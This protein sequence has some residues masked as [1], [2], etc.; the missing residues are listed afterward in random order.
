MLKPFFAAMP[1]PLLFLLSGLSMVVASYWFRYH[2]A[3]GDHW[4]WITFPLVVYS[5]IAGGVLALWSR[6]KDMPRLSPLSL[7]LCL[8][9][10]VFIVFDSQTFLRPTFLTGT[11]LFTDS[12][13]MAA[14]LAFGK[15]VFSILALFIALTVLFVSTGSLM[16]RITRFSRHI[17]TAE[18]ALRFVLQWIVGIGTWVGILILFHWIGLLGARPIL[19][20]IAI[21][22]LTER[23]RLIEVGRRCL[24][25]TEYPALQKPFNIVVSAL[26]LFLFAFNIVEAIRPIPTGYDD[27]THYMNRVSLITE[28]LTLP[29]GA[30]HYNF[31]LLA[32]GISIVTGESEEQMFALSLGVYGLLIGTL[33]TFLFGRARF[34]FQTGLVAA[35]TFLSLPMGPA[36]A[37]LETKPDSLLLPLT[38][39]LVWF[40]VEAV[41]IRHLPYFYF[42][43]F[44]F[45]LALG[46]KL[47]GAIFL[48]ALIL[49][50]I[51]IT[52]RHPIPW[53]PMLRVGVRSLFFFVLALAP[54]LIHAELGKVE[55]ALHPDT[56]TTLSE[57]LTTELWGSGE[58]CS[59]L[60][61][62]EDMLR[63]DPEPGW[64]L[65]ETVM[66]P[67]H[68]T[69]NRYVSLFATEF[70]FLYLALLPFGLLF[71]PFQSSRALLA[72]I[73]KPA[74]FIV[75]TAIGA[76]ILWGIYAEHIVWYLYPVF[77]LFSILITLVFAYSHNYRMLTWFLAALFIVGLMGNTAVRM[78]FGSS[79]PRLRYAAGVISGATYTESVF[80]GYRISMEVLNL[81]P[82]ARIFVTG[83]RHWYGIENSDTRAYMDTHLEAFSCLLNRHGP[84]GMLAALQR[85]DVRYILFSKSLLSE[86]DGKARPT[87]SKKIRDFVEFSRTHLR[88]EW[89][90][91]SHIIYR[92]P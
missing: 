65:K 56:S 79:E 8:V 91:A 2:I 88:V 90:S 34:G 11:P 42:A 37:L 24:N 70:G 31:E 77:P 22:L 85:L 54:W 78:K 14:N 57:D 39:A 20:L 48:P 67:W 68:L 46:T 89:G 86:L 74:A 53:I 61:Q 64:D 73:M 76:I 80:P 59:Y 84:D 60:G 17:A 45:G 83:S 6:S 81:Y 3:T 4:L 28:R 82:D 36:L 58:K 52:W 27:M 18:S 38:I 92:V 19:F 40:L 75:V 33:F 26:L 87:F 55:T 23:H 63:F 12:S 47:T 72:E 29:D 1:Y 69:M 51:V 50:F 44:T 9:G 66:A 71:V 30:L 41:R 32:A 43:C 10:A 15:L 21:I 35:T 25:T 13:I 16:L 49:G 7:F 62:T 5:V